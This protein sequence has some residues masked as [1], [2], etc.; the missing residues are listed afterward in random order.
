LTYLFIQYKI[1]PIKAK[2][3]Q[4]YTHRLE[5]IEAVLERWLPENPGKNW[6]EEAFPGLTDK[7]DPQLL[8]ALTAPGKDLLSRGGKRWRPLLMTLV[9]EALG[10]KDAALPLVPLVE[11]CHNAS[12]IHDDIE[13]NSDE[14]R[15]KPAVHITHGVDVAINSGCFLY[16]LPLACID[17]WAADPNYKL[18]VYSL[19][20]SYLRKLHLG[21]AMDIHWHRNP[22]LI[23]PLDEYF[24]M[25]KLKTGC[26]A[27]F[28]AE[29][30]AAVAEIGNEVASSSQ[31]ESAMQT[32]GVA[33]EKLGVG[34]Q[35]LD[36]VKNVTTG[37]PGKKRG[38]DIVEGKKSLPI[39]LFLHSHH[40][41][42]EMVFRCFKAARSSGVTAP[43][44]EEL[45]QALQA[46]GVLAEA[47]TQAKALIAEARE[48]FASPAFTAEGR[49]LLGGLV[50]MIS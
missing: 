5:K 46:S 37:I 33:A 30:G 15:G 28:A 22:E 17:S 29:L 21:Q 10:R 41:K 4:Q 18:K 40:E 16:F 43:E 12:L 8:Q 25:C 45:I 9:C 13:D 34:F 24:T 27:R 23:P 42:S 38:D 14:R 7:I 6:A 20:A 32:L 11:F 2:M 44:V 50:D 31:T 1:K 39:L 19:W 48:A 3:E 47:E 36:D 49:I 26:L 35:I